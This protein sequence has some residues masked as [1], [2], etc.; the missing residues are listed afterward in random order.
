MPVPGSL[1]VIHPE[2]GQPAFPT[3]SEH[4]LKGR[5]KQLHVRTASAQTALLPRMHVRPRC[6]S[7]GPSA[8]TRGA[9]VTRGAPGRKTED[10]WSWTMGSMAKFD[11]EP[12][13]EGPQKA[14]RSL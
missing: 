9:L 13:V 10:R 1:T 2:A 3:I 4:L 14:Y 11:T 7:Y 8:G 5:P 6:S 12:K